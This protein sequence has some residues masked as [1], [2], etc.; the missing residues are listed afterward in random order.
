MQADRHVA[1]QQSVHRVC[2]HLHTQLAK[3]CFW[4]VANCVYIHKLTRHM[5]V[6]ALANLHDNDGWVI[7]ICYSNGC[8]AI[9]QIGL[10]KWHLPF[11]AVPFVCL[12]FWTALLQFEHLRVS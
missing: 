2:W 11:D 3:I 8:Y 12:S 7:G 1:N 5:H 6:V 9:W 4:L 10:I